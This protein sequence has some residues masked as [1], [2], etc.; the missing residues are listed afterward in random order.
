[1]SSILNTYA[2]KKI[3]F[4]KGK[5]CYLYADDGKKYLDFVQGIAVNSLGHCHSHLIKT[6]N[7]QS[8]K[9][10]HVSNAFTILEQEKLAQRLCKHTFAD[11]VAFQNSGTE[12]TEL[13]IKLARKYF[14]S[15]G[16]KNK[17][18]VVTFQGAFHGRTLAALFAANNPK[19]IEGFGP[20]VNGFDQVPFADH[21][22]L[23]KAVTDD[24]AAI[25]VEPIFGE[26]GV[27]VVR[28]YCIKGIRELCDEKDVLLILDEVQCGVGRTGKFFAF[29]HTGVIPDIVPI[30]KGIGSGF[31]I[32]ACLMTKKVASSMTP[33]SHGSTFGGNPLAMSV[34]NAVLDII[35]KKGF[36]KNVQKISK[37]FHKELHKLQSEYPKVVKEV[38]GAGLLAGLEISKDQTEFIK[39]LSDNKLLTV[40]ASENVV[41]LLP[42]LTV[43]KQNID[44]AVII[45]KKV[46]KTYR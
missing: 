36:L 37:Y 30:A 7:K 29:E 17:N 15:Q 44:E 22:A 40:K 4:K 5:G 9:L 3:S 32:G 13:A 8:K 10:W 43:K 34:G 35:F 39:K 24:T 20:K 33:G 31:P 2:R 26:G 46:C 14:Y 38:R 28:D 18:K 6:I 16:K 23:K 41:R 45:L 21:E 1:M 27:K 42:P 12:A 19:H 25:M 11:A